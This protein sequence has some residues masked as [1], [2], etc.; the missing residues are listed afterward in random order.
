MM[1]HVDETYIRVSGKWRY[2]WRIVDEHGRFV[3]FRLTA[4]RD[5]KAAKAFLKAAQHNSGH[6]PPATLV[7]DKA[8]LPCHYQV[9]GPASLLQQTGCSHQ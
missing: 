6:Y 4:R 7:T 2:L 9:H 3:D 1:W 8:H 5:S